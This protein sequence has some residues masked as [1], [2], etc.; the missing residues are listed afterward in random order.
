M[1]WGISTAVWIYPL[2]CSN[3]TSFLELVLVLFLVL[4][5]SPVL[6]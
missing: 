1:M 2:N 5:A 3:L 4:L 6:E